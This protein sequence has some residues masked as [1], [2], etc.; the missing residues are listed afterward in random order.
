MKT[1]KEILAK[2][3][4]LETDARDPRRTGDYKHLQHL[5]PRRAS[6]LMALQWVLGNVSSI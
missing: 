3:K 1:K 6:K 2:I 5:S 4:E